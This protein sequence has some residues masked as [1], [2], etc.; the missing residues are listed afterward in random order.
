MKRAIWPF[1][2]RIKIGAYLIWELGLHDVQIP[3]QCQVEFAELGVGQDFKQLC[4]QLPVQA[5]QPALYPILIVLQ[6]Q[7]YACRYPYEVGAELIDIVSISCGAQHKV[8]A[9]SP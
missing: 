6:I 7:G 2:G 4:L 5:I 1:W 8:C 3:G 9:A